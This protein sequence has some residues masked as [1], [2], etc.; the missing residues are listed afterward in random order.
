[1]KKDIRLHTKT[2]SEKQ[3]NTNMVVS[4]F[5]YQATENALCMY[6]KWLIYNSAVETYEVQFT[7]AIHVRVE[8][9]FGPSLS[10]R[11]FSSL[12]FNGAL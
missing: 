1:M 3:T 2:K 11:F 10:G 9:C 12:W 8:V 6:W 5:I 7:S 4:D